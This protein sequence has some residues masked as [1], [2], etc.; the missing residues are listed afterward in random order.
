[1][2]RIGVDVVRTHAGL[3]EFRGRVAL[4]DRVLARAED[5]DAGGAVL[6][7][8][9]L[10]LRGHHVESLVPA[11][12]CELP[13]LVVHAVFLAE[14]RFREA[15]LAV[16]DLGVEVALDAGEP[17]IDGRFRV[18]L[19]GDDSPLVGGHHDAAADSAEAAHRFVPLP[20]LLILPL[21]DLR[22]G[23]LRNRDAD[24]SG[25]RCGD[26]VLQ[27]VTSGLAHDRLR[28]KFV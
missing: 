17:A 9:L 28:L 2:S 3:H 8:V 13:V 19:Y 24:A 1:M 15:I 14:Q 21:V 11:D 20:A 22:Q 10:E 16:H 27:K 6:L 26:R 12:R 5:R 25:H 7:V 18:A 4:V 23:A